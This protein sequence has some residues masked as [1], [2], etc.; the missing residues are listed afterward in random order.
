[1][2]LRLDVSGELLVIAVVGFLDEGTPFARVVTPKVL[3]CLPQ[4][5]GFACH[6]FGTLVAADYMAWMST[7]KNASRWE[8]PLGGLEIGEPFPV[9][10]DD[11]EGVVRNALE[12]CALFHRANRDAPVIE[13]AETVTPRP[14]LENRFAHS[15]KREVLLHR[16][17]LEAGFNRVFSLTG[18]STGFTIDYIGHAYAT[19]YAAIDPKSRAFVRLRAASA[20]LWRLARARDAFGFATPDKIE[21]TAWT[22]APG[23]PIYSEREYAVVDDTIAELGEQARREGLDVFPVFD[24]NNASE[25]LISEEVAALN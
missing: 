8:A 21:L 6:S 25:R 7:G 2:K 3:K 16:P 9:D 15:V 1:M 13:P 20:A 10:A 24:A 11:K 4:E 22:P 19:C 17:S 23:L 5:L 12:R 14:A 18:S